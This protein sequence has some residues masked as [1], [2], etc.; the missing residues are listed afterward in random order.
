[1][2]HTKHSEIIRNESTVRRRAWIESA[3]K[4]VKARLGFVPEKDMCN[5]IGPESDPPN[6]YV[7]YPDRRI[8]GADRRAAQADRRRSGT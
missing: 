3:L 5:T 7:A 1:M 4:G 8:P 2:S 6:L